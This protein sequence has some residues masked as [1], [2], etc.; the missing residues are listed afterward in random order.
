MIKGLKVE[1]SFK[2]K[3]SAVEDSKYRFLLTKILS[4]MP[5]TIHVDDWDRK[6]DLTFYVLMSDIGLNY[7]DYSK[8]EDEFFSYFF[9]NFLGELFV[10]ENIKIFTEK[11]KEY[12]FNKYLSSIEEHGSHKSFGLKTYKGKLI[13]KFHVSFL[14]QILSDNMRESLG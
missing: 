8:Y 12:K 13:F 4:N 14:S 2:N 6:G 10:R 3:F 7:D 5:K 11:L 9:I 1:G